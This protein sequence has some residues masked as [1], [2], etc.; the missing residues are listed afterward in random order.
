[1]A[2]IR[3][4]SEKTQ[5]RDRQGSG[6]RAKHFIRPGDRAI[7]VS[8]VFFWSFWSFG[9]FLAPA[10]PLAPRLFGSFSLVLG[11]LLLWS[12]FFLVF[13]SSYFLLSSTRTR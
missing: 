10:T 2:R 5:A 11:H 8:L 6:K 9:V 7:L 1:M 4:P 13:F 12:F 3:D